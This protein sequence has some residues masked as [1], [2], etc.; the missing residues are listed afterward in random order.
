MQARL[1]NLLCSFFDGPIHRCISVIHPIR[2]RVACVCSIA[3]IV[4]AITITVWL[5]PNPPGQD[6]KGADT[7]I[8]Q[9]VLQPLMFL[10]WQIMFPENTR[11]QAKNTGWSRNWQCQHAAPPLIAGI[12]AK[13]M[14]GL[15]AFMTLSDKLVFNALQPAVFKLGLPNEY[16]HGIV[17]GLHYTLAALLCFAAVLINH[18]G[19]SSDQP[20]GGAANKPTPSILP[21]VGPAPQGAAAHQGDRRAA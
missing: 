12:F 19:G 13:G 6:N 2:C 11:D 20:A 4:T 18:R 16:G 3:I 7:W 10:L 17:V 1:D 5:N 9:F 15:L 21:F 8:H 14:V